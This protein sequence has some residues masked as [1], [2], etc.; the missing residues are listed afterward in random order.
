VSISHLWNYANYGGMVTSDDKS[1]LVVN[2]GP[3]E[4]HRTCAFACV[5]MAVCWDGSITAC[6]CADAEGLGLTIGRADRDSLAEVWS[7][8]RRSGILGAFGKGNLPEVCRKCSA[9][10]PDTLLGSPALHDLTPRCP[11]PVE[12]YRQFWGA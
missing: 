10:Q 11:L 6:G 4:K 1:G 5:H 2:A 7:G 3:A 12:F 8:A 9:Y